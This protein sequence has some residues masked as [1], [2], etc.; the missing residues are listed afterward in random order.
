MRLDGKKGVFYQTNFAPPDATRRQDEVGEAVLG[1]YRKRAFLPN[2]FQTES[3]TLESD[4]QNAAPRCHPSFPRTRRKRSGVREFP[5]RLYLR[6]RGGATCRLRGKR[7]G[8]GRPPGIK[9]LGDTL[10]IGENRSILPNE[11]RNRFET[12][13]NELRFA[14]TLL[15]LPLLGGNATCPPQA[16]R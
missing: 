15:C 1:T 6:E 11:L 14:Q 12:A 13:E 10:L 16:I 8:E 2:N 5:R 7:R 4:A 9:G 3:E